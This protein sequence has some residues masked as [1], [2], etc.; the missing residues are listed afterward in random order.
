MAADEMTITEFRADAFETINRVVY[1]GART[2]LTRRGKPVAVL[3]PYD[4]GELVER[5]L[6]LID[7]GD[8]VSILDDPEGN[9]RPAE[10][11]F[12]ELGL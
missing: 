6:D 8:V 10:E 2:V 7:L 5:L 3:V 4:V 9:S 1:Q 12:E 11:I